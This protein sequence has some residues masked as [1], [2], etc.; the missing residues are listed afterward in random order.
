[1]K[2]MKFKSIK[3]KIFFG[4]S[5]VILL[6]LMLGTFNYYAINMV[7][8]DTENIVEDEL[9][10]LVANE[11][12]AFNMSQRIALTRGYILYGDE[13]FKNRYNEYTQRSLEEQEL[14][15]EQTDSEEVKALIDKSN[16]W[17][18]LV[19]YDVFLAYDSGN[20]EKATRI[21][22]EEVQP[23]AREIMDGFEK[24]S[25]EGEASIEAS[26]QDII[27]AGNFVLFIGMIVSV[28]VVLIAIV[29]ALVTARVIANPIKVVMNRMKAISEGDLSHEPLETKS[30]DEVGQLV[31]ATNDMND[32]M[33]KLLQQI[34][35]MTDTVSSHS[36]GLT[37]SA[38]EVKDGAE[39]IT[40]TM[41]EIASGSESQA[42]SASDL[43]DYMSSFATKVEEA[44][45][46]GDSIYQSSDEV[47]TLTKDG[48]QL[49]QS[50]VNQMSMIDDLV[51]NAVVK[52][53]GLDHQSQEISKL[54]S[55]IRDI[56]EQTNL[57][58]LNAAIEAARAGEQGKGFAVVA[59]EVRKL[60]E[61]VGDSVTEITGIVDGIQVESSGVVTSLQD[62]YSEVEKGTEQIKATGETFDKITG[63]VNNMADRIQA[64]TNNLSTI[65]SN[66]QEMNSSVQEIASISEESAAGVEETSASAEQVNSSMEEVAS[67][68]DE[69]SKLAEE[70]NGLVRQ[71]KL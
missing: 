43:S 35:N 47:L 68:S 60:A 26:G 2:L 17:R 6:V 24:L 67:S 51:Q 45:S 48:S 69:L 54:V 50:S 14:L 31:V 4:F 64:V 5:L 15:L 29:T 23:M 71:F 57:L 63:A 8:K 58:A 55:V 38:N 56:A 16:E 37:Q 3:G 9:P 1:M 25:E 44:N 33:R 41:Q 36:E 52:V 19:D 42:N 59:D 11:K 61:Q 53:K 28:L 49:M 18:Q 70:L 66:T 10:S 12:L 21:L 46:N 20:E 32:S 7:N 39:Q 40:T 13:E 62:G 34:S 27:E 22:L 30:R 65:S